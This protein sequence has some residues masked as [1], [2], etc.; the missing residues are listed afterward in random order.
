MSADQTQ[1]TD[2]MP[3]EMAS[4]KDGG[5]GIMQSLPVL[6]AAGCSFAG[7]ILMFIPSLVQNSAF[8]SGCSL[9]LILGAA[10]VGTAD[11]LSR[12]KV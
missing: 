5:F 12:S 4:R 3:V 10:A 11:L 9:G 6:I 8:G 7:L 2:Q 1:T